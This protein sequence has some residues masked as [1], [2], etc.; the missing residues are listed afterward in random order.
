[1]ES[2]LY[3]M[4]SLNLVKI[5]SEFIMLTLF[6]GEECL[7]KINQLPIDD[8]VKNKMTKQI[9]DFSTTL[10]DIAQFTRPEGDAE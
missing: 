4:K 7:N 1:M 5:Q 2:M 9:D 10:V 8:E 6:H 3:K